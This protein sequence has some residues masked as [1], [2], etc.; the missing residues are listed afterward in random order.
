M[1]DKMLEINK[2][3][4]ELQAQAEAAKSEREQY[5]QENGITDGQERMNK[6]IEDARLRH[7][8]NQ[9]RLGIVTPEDSTVKSEANDSSLSSSSISSQQDDLS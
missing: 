7:Q 8:K 3:I 4:A 2:M 9:E 1:N 6:A 5:E